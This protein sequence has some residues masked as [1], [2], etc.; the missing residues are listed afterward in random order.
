MIGDIWR[1]FRRLPGWVQ[2]WVVLMLVPVNSLSLLL[3]GQPGGGLVAALAVGA[4][5]L[6]LPIMLVERGFSKAMAWPHVAL[7]TPL[8]PILVGML[9]DGGMAP[10][11]RR[12]LAILLAVDAISLA[13]DIPDA[14]KWLRGDRSIA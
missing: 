13:F 4:M 10:G 6:N 14:W 11:A 9:A 2:A 8:V 3:V 7:W 12:Y 5:L 1:S